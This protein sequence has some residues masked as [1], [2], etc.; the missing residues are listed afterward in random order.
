VLALV[1]C[2]SVPHKA[3]YYVN[4]QAERNIVLTICKGNTRKDCAAHL[5]DSSIFVPLTT[6][7]VVQ[8]YELIVLLL[9][10]NQSFLKVFDKVNLELCIVL[11]FSPLCLLLSPIIT[12]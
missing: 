4:I 3:F 7:Q 9:K 6:D 2:F 8:N 1:S 12:L 10:F 5:H 11:D